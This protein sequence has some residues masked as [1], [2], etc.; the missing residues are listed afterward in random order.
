MFICKLLFRAFSFSNDRSRGKTTFGY[1]IFAEMI[2]TYVS[3][4]IMKYIHRPLVFTYADKFAGVLIPKRIQCANNSNSDNNDIIYIYIYIY[5]YRYT[6]IS[7]FY[8]VKAHFPDHLLHPV[9]TNRQPR[10]LPASSL[11]HHRHVLLLLLA[12]AQTKRPR[13]PLLPNPTAFPSSLAP[14]LITVSTDQSSL[15]PIYKTHRAP[16]RPQ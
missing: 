9:H 2:R 8:P 15:I 5:I 3:I 11:P 10:T 4:Y 7:N 1:L 16:H 12:P 13:Q 14:T 6:R